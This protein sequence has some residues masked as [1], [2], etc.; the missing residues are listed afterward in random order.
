MLTRTVVF[1]V[2]PYKDDDM[3]VVVACGL[4]EKEDPEETRHHVLID[5]LKKALITSDGT[6]INRAQIIFSETFTDQEI[7]FMA[8]QGL[9]DIMSDA[10]T[11]ISRAMTYKNL[12]S[13]LTGRLP[14]DPEIKSVTQ[15]DLDFFE[16]FI[17]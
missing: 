15:E 7:L 13:S 14:P 2:D 12:P 1:S 17:K 11:V 8:A 10:E 9:R 4:A 6:R 5:I 3:S 16:S